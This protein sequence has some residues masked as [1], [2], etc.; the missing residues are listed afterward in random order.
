MELGKNLTKQIIGKRIRLVGATAIE[1]RVMAVAFR[2]YGIAL[3]VE[4]VVPRFG[5]SVTIEDDT[6][7]EILEDDA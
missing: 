7:V 4:G 2:P 5:I 3:E 6:E 1:G